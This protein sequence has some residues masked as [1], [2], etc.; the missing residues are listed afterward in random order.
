MELEIRHNPEIFEQESLLRWKL[1]WKKKIELHLL[2]LSIGI[3]FLF[4]SI[5]QIKNDDKMGSVFISMSLFLVFVSSNFLI[6]AAKSKKK[7]RIR[8]KH[9]SD[10]HLSNNSVVRFSLTDEFFK[11]SDFQQSFQVLWSVLGNFT[12]LNDTI[13]IRIKDHISYNFSISKLEIGEDKFNE[14]IAFLSNKIKRT[15]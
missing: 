12:V 6:T 5:M 4:V 10:L 15:T 14:T 3:V 13:L 9:S 7:F 1:V 2:Y 11:Y 8:I